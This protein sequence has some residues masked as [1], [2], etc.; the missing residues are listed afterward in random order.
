MSIFT[1]ECRLTYYILG[2]SKVYSL[3]NRSFSQIFKFLLVNNNIIMLLKFI[4]N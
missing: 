2:Q 3:I 1:W 4:V